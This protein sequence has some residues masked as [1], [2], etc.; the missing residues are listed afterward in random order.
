MLVT[1]NQFDSLKKIRETLDKHGITKFNSIGEV[2]TFLRNYPN[3]VQDVNKKIEEELNQELSKL[4]ENQINLQVKLRQVQESIKTKVFADNTIHAYSNSD[5]YFESIVKGVFKWGQKGVRFAESR[6]LKLSS[7]RLTTK[8]KSI[9]GQLFNL[10]GNKDSL[11]KQRATIRLQELHHTKTILEMVNPLIAGAIGEH[12]VVKELTNMDIDGFLIND[13]Q[14]S[15]S[16]SIY[17]KK[18]NDKIRSIQVDHLLVCTSGIFILETKNWSK[19][20][21]EQQDLRSP[22]AQILRSSY[23]I[24]ILVHKQSEIKLKPHHWGQK[25]IPVRN[26]IVMIKHKPKESFR[27]VKVKTLSELA[28][29]LQHFESI[30]DHDEVKAIADYLLNCQSDEG[31][32]AKMYAPSMSNNQNSYQG[33]TRR[34]IND[35]YEDRWR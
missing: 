24:N 11:I 10:Y 6:R 4:R 2:K 1:Y 14:A 32:T 21:I 34:T 29:Y 13:F 3:Q 5:S 22:I 17:N 9:D 23:A 33:K 8:I 27:Y 16:P 28:G 31:S 12:K 7:K 18:E 20:S 26:V 25:E 15:F 19:K 30:F 35:I